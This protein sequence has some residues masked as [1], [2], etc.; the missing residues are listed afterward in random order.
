M[1]LRNPELEMLAA[2]RAAQPADCFTQ[3]VTLQMLARRAEA[4]AQMRQ[5][6]VDV[7][8]TDPRQL[9]PK[10]LDRYLELKRRLRF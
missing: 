1:A 2:A 4:L 3:A 10:L 9:T 8:D 5:H 6:G 7:L